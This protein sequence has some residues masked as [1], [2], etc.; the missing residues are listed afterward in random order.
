MSKLS[1]LFWRKMAKKYRKVA[2]FS[3]FDWFIIR[4]V[5]CIESALV[6]KQ[7]ERIEILLNYLE[8]QL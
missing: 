4:Y 6:Q 2:L 8:E 3:V 5:I 7:V 1:I